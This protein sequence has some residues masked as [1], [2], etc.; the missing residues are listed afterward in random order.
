M[1][2]SDLCLCWLLEVLRVHFEAQQYS[3]FEAEMLDCLVMRLVTT[4]VLTG[5][6]MVA[7]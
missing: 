1:I 4:E 2:P 5:Q 7:S 3:L 6:R